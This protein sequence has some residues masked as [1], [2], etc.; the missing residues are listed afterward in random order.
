MDAFVQLGASA[1]STFAST[2][3]FAI[4]GLSAFATSSVIN[5][6]IGAPLDFF[7]QNS[8]KII[9]YTMI[10]IILVVPFAYYKRFFTY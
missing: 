3:G 1:T 5:A 4:D 9:A 7:Y 2:T 8:V 10:F 6:L